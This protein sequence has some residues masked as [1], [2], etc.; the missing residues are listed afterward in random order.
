[1]KKILVTT[2]LSKAS[3]GAIEAAKTFAR[4]TAAEI[5]LLCVVE[6]PSQAAMA[7][8]LDFPV[9]PDPQVQRDLLHRLQRELQSIARS[10]F[11]DVVVTTEVLEASG[12]VHSAV[13]AFAKEHQ[14]DLIVIATHGRTGVRHLLIGSVTERLVR[15]SHC[16]VLVVPADP[17]RAKAP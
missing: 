3:L 13:L 2:D 14:V 8:A 12:P 5:I 9:L 4:T 15:E 17:G 10:S 11:G 7:Y 6:D 16:P 1:M